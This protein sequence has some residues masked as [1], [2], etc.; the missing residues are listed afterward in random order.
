MRV[1]PPNIIPA[2]ILV[3]RK[4]KGSMVGSSLVIYEIGKK[5]PKDTTF[6]LKMS[7]LMDILI[8]CVNFSWTLPDYSAL[9]RKM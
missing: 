3:D 1:I 7:I 8:L 9:F 5:T 6:G 4:V 2:T